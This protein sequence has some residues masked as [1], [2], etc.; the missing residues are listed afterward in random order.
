V[1][2]EW[3]GRATSDAFFARAERSSVVEFP[4]PVLVIM[5]GSPT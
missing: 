1:N 5:L 3:R 2:V 4:A